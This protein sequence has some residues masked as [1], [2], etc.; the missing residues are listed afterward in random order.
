VR[1]S[2][3]APDQVNCAENLRGHHTVCTRLITPRS[4]RRPP[5]GT[6]GHWATTTV[7][8]IYAATPEIALTSGPSDGASVRVVLVCLM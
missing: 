1:I 7:R 6:A 3:N 5:A 2:R 8:A 4:G